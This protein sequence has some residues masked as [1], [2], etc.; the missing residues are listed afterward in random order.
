MKEALYHPKHGYYA[1]AKIGREGDFYTNVSVGNLFGSLMAR[2]FFEMWQVLGEPKTFDICEQGAHN[3]QFAADVLQF[4][5]DNHPQCFRACRYVII[6]SLSALKQKQKE[7]LE[8]AK[9]SKKI[10]WIDSLSK[11]KK[12]SLE[13]VFFSNELLDSFPVCLVTFSQGKWHEKFVIWKNNEFQFILRPIQNLG[14]KKAIP[15][16]PAIEGYETEICLS[17]RGWVQQVARILRRGFVLTMDYGLLHDELYS[18]ERSK[19]TL[20]CY[21]Q[22]KA[23]DNPLAHIGEQ[24]ITAHVNFSDLMEAGD[25]A[26]LQTLAFTDQH[27]FLIGLA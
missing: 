2:Q 5:H 27:H 10:R 18:C 16:L 23:S 6:E 20:R 14:L 1:S 22:H 19:G 13:G 24:D 25:K 8:C 9:L 3:G 7:F 26:G 4:L 17:I 15:H 21:H 11:I 12:E